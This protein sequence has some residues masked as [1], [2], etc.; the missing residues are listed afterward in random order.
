MPLPAAAPVQML[1]IRSG[2]SLWLQAQSGIVWLTCEG[3]LADSFLHPGQSLRLTGPA[4][5]Y[6][7]A[8]G[9]QNSQDASLRWR[10][11]ASSP[12]VA[13]AAASALA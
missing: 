5:L 11:V 1:R 9:S 13:A 4:T 7:G 10:D 12:A 6:L 3:Q 2:Q 8:Q